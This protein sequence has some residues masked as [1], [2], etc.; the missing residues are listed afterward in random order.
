MSF[1]IVRYA[2]IGL[3][4]KNRIKFERK[5]IDNIRSCLDRNKIDFGDIQKHMGRIL[6]SGA[7]SCGP[8]NR[9]FGISSFS[10]AVDAGF[11]MDKVRTVALD[12]VRDKIRGKSFC[13]SCRRLD[14]K[15]PVG[16][17]EF[18][19]Q[20]G[21]FIHEKF[22]ADV[23]LKNPGLTLYTEIIDGFVYLFTEISKGLGGLPLGI[24]GNVVVV[25]DTESALL[26]ALLMMKRGC[27]VF[28]VAKRKRDIGLLKNFVYGS[29]VEVKV[30][31]TC[32]EIEV[33]AREK[34]AKA[35]IVPDTLNS[36]KD[37]DFA[38][39]VYRPLCAMSKKQIKEKLNEF[40]QRVC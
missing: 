3:K 37:Y 33:F 35:I 14:K 27:G 19:R 22:N 11:S 21:A 4:G 32:K 36:S 39:P 31:K 2:E 30:L 23:D 28:C 26:A 13:V 15:F 7:G 10:D 8:L 29:K 1:C 6:I 34:R 25:A 38:L 9:V 20:L 12:L 5:L 17:Q 18:S 40:R 24:E 16:S